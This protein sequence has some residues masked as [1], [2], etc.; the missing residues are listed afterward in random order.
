[1]PEPAEMPADLAKALRPEKLAKLSAADKKSLLARVDE[2]EG[3]LR[4][5][6][7]EAKR[8]DPFW[9]YKPST[10]EL[11]EDRRAF[12]ERHLRPEDVPLK[13]PGQLDV[14]TSLA[15][16][17]GASGGNRSGKTTLGAIE[18]FI[19]TTGCLPDSLKGR[20]PIHRVPTKFPRHVRVTGKDWENGILGT[21]LPEYQFWA[22]REFLPDGDWRKAWSA[23]KATLHL[24][25]KG[26][27]F[28][29]IEFMSNAQPVTAFQGPTK[30]KQIYDEEPS[31][32]IYKENL[33]RFGT[34]DFIDNLFCM[35]PTEGLSWIYDLVNG[36]KDAR[37]NSVEWFKLPSV[38][39]ELVNLTV[40]ET[41]AQFLSYEDKLMRWLGEFVS[42][43]GLVYGRLFSKKVH[44]IA[45]F[46]VGCN[47][48]TT[49]DIHA[50]ACPWNHYYVVSGMDPHLVTPTAVCWVA[51]DRWGNKYVVDSWFEEADTELVKEGK[52]RREASFRMGW[53]VTDSAADSDIKA[54][55]GLNIFKKLKSGANKIRR[56]ILATKGAG[57]IKTGVDE[58]KEGLRPHPATGRPQLYIMDTPGNQL[59]IRAF[60]TMERD[61]GI[62]E[63]KKGARDKILESKHHLHAALRYIFMQKLIWRSPVQTRVDEMEAAYSEEEVFA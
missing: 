40:L 52:K 55:N 39:N 32:E 18:A 7:E 41:Q 37:G 47:C 23:E 48:G 11:T 17:R 35:T 36:G 44:K 49:N 45:P 5:Q 9:F 12:L 21:V 19:A 3:E 62:Q 42:M 43:S 1:M 24:Q 6:E 51:L 16:V 10:G 38:T 15:T 61:R 58:L 8:A 26:R 34:A 50:D 25:K 14:H 2:W 46:E 27:I 22:P 28:G 60:E 54:F 13:C 63:D 4:R 53:T 59:L 57:S 30:H 20:Y 29:T 56:L 33:M 31:Q